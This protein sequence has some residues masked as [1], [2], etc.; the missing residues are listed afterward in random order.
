MSID[1]TLEHLHALEL[2]TPF[3]VGPVTVYVAEAPAEA[4]GE[5]LTLIDTGPRT[6]DTQAALESGLAQ[7]GYSPGDLGRLVVTHAHADHFGLAADLVAASGAE[8]WTHPWN[9]AALDDYETDRDQRVAF[10][11]ELLRQAAVPDEVLAVVGTATQGVSRFAR[12]VGVDGTLDEGDRLQLAGREWQV[13]HTPGHTAGLICLYEPQSRTLLSSD[14]LLADISSN[15]V[16]EPPPPGQAERLR[17]LALY[18]ASLQRVA[19]MDIARALPSHG[20]VIHD[21]AA[22]VERRLAFHE[23]RLARVLEALR[24][25]ARTTWDVTHAL[26]PDTSPLDTFLAVSEVIGHLDLLEME[27]R[28][29]AQ[30]AGGVL[31]WELT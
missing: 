14:H 26:F 17:S 18:R 28:I 3:P 24:Y 4:P 6:R 15:P 21:V 30:N 27:G 7:L 19:D 16:V 23:Q 2:P 11:A 22:L 25:G 9:V 12:P 29:A 13:L 5:P 20:P 8:V 10:Y 31:V 1:T